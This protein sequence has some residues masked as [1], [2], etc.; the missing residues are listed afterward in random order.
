MVSNPQQRISLAEKK[1]KGIYRN[2]INRGIA[3]FPFEVVNGFQNVSNLGLLPN[4]PRPNP[5][6]YTFFQKIF[7]GM[8]P[9]QI[10]WRGST[11]ADKPKRQIGN[12]NNYY[13]K[14]LRSGY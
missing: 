3:V 2:V 9:V 4:Y 7:T 10:T 8:S 12:D 14:T 11:R 5:E 1:A 13:V 6:D